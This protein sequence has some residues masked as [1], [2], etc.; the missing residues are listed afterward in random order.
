MGA[1]DWVLVDPDDGLTVRLQRWNGQGFEP[2]SFYLIDV[3]ALT[4]DETEVLDTA[5]AYG[6]Y[7][8]RAWELVRRT[9]VEVSRF[10]EAWELVHEL[11]MGYLLSGPGD[12]DTFAFRVDGDGEELEGVVV[13]RFA[14]GESVEIDGLTVSVGA[15]DLPAVL[16]DCG[17][18]GS[19]LAPV[20]WAVRS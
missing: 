20:S 7:D 2:C 1:S 11:E 19:W 15:G 13:Q 4:E 5:D 14:V 8:H 6:H 17:D 18:R 10:V 12:F 16:V 9:G 3:N